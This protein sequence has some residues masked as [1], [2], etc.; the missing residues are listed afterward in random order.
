MINL[1]NQS[2]G[3]VCSTFIVMNINHN[4]TNKELIIELFPCVSFTKVRGIL[5][6]VKQNFNS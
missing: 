3:T 6:A 2:A 4:F 5:H 1:P